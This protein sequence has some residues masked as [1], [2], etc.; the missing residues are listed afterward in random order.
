MM[1]EMVFG[2]VTSWCQLYLVAKTSHIVV[3]MDGLA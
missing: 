3:D 2:D 1:P